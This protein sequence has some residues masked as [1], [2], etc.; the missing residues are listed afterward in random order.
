MAKKFGVNVFCIKKSFN[1]A[2]K[3]IRLW[4]ITIDYVMICCFA[5]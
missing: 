5:S 3:M 2:V 4:N 1:F